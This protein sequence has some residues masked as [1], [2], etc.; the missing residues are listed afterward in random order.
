MKKPI[1]RAILFIATILEEI[2]TKTNGHPLDNE[3]KVVFKMVLDEME[4]YK[5]EDVTDI[6]TGTALQC[7]EME[8]QTRRQC[9]AKPCL[10][11]PIY[12]EVKDTVD[13]PFGSVFS[14]EEAIKEVLNKYK[15]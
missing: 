2:E 5:K 15:Q 13:I 11:C 1:D 8:K 4:R 14:L 7:M 12:Q 10:V 6:L 9:G 3:N